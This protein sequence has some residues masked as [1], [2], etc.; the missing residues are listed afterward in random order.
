MY[1]LLFINLCCGLSLPPYGSKLLL[2]FCPDISSAQ[3]L[4]HPKQTYFILKY[5]VDIYI[6]NRV[7]LNSYCN[8]PSLHI[9]SIP[10]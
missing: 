1:L 2:M 8:Y 4:V 7:E 5:I 10:I 9:T 6:S 3:L